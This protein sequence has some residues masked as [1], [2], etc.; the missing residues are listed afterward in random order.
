SI[1]YLA[2]GTNLGDR[3]AN[4][5]AAITAL[6]PAVRV[7]AQSPVYETPPWGLTDQPA[8]LNMVLKSQ[9]ALAPVELL[10]HLKLLETELGRLPT[11]RWGPRRID[12]DILFYDKLIL[13]TPELTIPHPRL[14]ERAFV[15]VPL[16]DLEPDLVHPVLGATI[17][18]LR[19]ALDTTG[20]KRYEP[21]D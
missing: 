17:K 8:F 21:T 2:L 18:Q 6:P 10:K 13:D 11:V 20:V 14:H 4:L 7:L 15:L 16:A 9:T 5:Q 3:F 1:I 12:M 19:S